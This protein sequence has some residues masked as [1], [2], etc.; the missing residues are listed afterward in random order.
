MIKERDT[1]NAEEH[2]KAGNLETAL[3]VLQNTIQMYPGHPEPRLHLFQLLSIMGDWNRAMTQLNEVAEIDHE[4]LL[5]AQIYSELLLCEAFRA[6]VFNGNREPL[7]YGEP[8]NWVAALM[9]SMEHS[10]NG[11][12]AQASALVMEAM[13]HAAPRSGTINDEPF[14]WISDADMRLG[15][16]FEIILDGKYYWVPIENI[17]E[18][19]FSEP[20]NL[21]DLVW[22]PIQVQ[23]VNSG[24]SG[25]FMPTRY[26][27]PAT[28]SDAQ[29][30]LAR[31]TDW[32][33]IGEGFYTGSG[34]RMF[35]TENDE[36]S[37]L[38]TRKIVFDTD[39]HPG[40]GIAIT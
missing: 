32:T 16:V 15:P 38:Q 27:G 22:L 6:E 29:S 23:W 2:I 40:L 8:T 28:L 31:K 5:L 34:Q 25:G 1:V 20:E 18:I 39:R 30:A 11:N 36:Y 12:G 21:R 10:E 14:L 4:A 19:T 3:E 17:S 9:R 35:T 7:L 13:D 26:P 24:S 33:D 37:L